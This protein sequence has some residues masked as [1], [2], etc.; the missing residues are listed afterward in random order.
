LRAAIGKVASGQTLTQAEAADAFERIMSGAASP[1]QIGALLMGMAVR[2]ET[3]DEIAG[4]A[5]VMRA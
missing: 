3:V 5:R 1:A 2:G 4:A